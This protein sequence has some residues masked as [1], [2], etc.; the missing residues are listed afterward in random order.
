MDARCYSDSDRV[1][2][3]NN[4]NSNINTIVYGNCCATYRNHSRHGTPCHNLGCGNTIMVCRVDINKPD[5][6]V[7]LFFSVRGH[8]ELGAAYNKI[9]TAYNNNSNNKNG[10]KRL[11]P[12][13][14]P[15]PQEVWRFR[16]QLM[17]LQATSH[18]LEQYQVQ[19]Q[20]ERAQ[21]KRRGHFQLMTLQDRSHH[22]NPVPPQGPQQSD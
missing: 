19:A 8:H 12:P 9:V 20:D 4:N 16:R 3:F 7:P 6:D 1:A 5:V 18:Q 14:A 15:S 10:P 13:R 17:T 21:V 11:L 2:I 22:A